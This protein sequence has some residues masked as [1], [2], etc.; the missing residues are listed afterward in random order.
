MATEADTVYI[1]PR[2]AADDKVHDP[3]VAGV[4]SSALFC[5]Y[6]LSTRRAATEAFDGL[7][8]RARFPSTASS[9]RRMSLRRSSIAS[10]CLPKLRSPT[11]K[12]GRC[13]LPAV[14]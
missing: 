8:C 13:L 11:L 12:A 5:A 7:A 1:S 9:A 14:K 6:L 4:S 3:T 2:G 10:V